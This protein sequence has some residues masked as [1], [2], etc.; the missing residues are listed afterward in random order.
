MMDLGSKEIIKGAHDV[1][2]GELKDDAEDAEDQQSMYIRKM[3]SVKPSPVG[4]IEVA[5]LPRMLDARGSS[6][7]VH[8]KTNKLFG[9]INEKQTY[10]LDSI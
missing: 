7:R 1:N 4:Q 9:P 10:E 5:A 3:D 8:L 2:V 6:L